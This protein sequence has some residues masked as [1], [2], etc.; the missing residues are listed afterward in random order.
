MHSNA[1]V[2]DKFSLAG[3]S[4][5]V[6][7]AGQGI[8]KALSRALAEAG[9]SVAVADLNFETATQTAA[10]LTRAG[11]T[12]FPIQADVA[13]PESVKAMVAHALSTL[14]RLDIAFNNAGI[15]YNSAAED[16]TLEEW[17][18]TFAVNLRG[19]FLCCQE[20]GRAM[21][22]QGGGVI[23][24]MA[25]MSSL[26]VPHPQKQ[27]VYNTAKAGVAHLSRSL[28]AE[29]ASRNVR[30][31]ALSPGLINTE[32]LQSDALRDLRG[33][34]LPQIPMGRFGEVGDLEGAIV[35]L[36]SDASAYMTGQNLV[37]DGGVTL[38]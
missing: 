4:A 5:L 13:D 3:R 34:W 12:S 26:V 2:L 11:A 8:G 9:A 22:A 14:G 30:V 25:S 28:A 7:G 38:W 15:N 1:N 6:T 33:E 35:F 37:L 31:N 32:L 36:A 19:V 16:T 21:L 29:W 17:D 20:E 24:N 23:V 18:R 10:E 27:A